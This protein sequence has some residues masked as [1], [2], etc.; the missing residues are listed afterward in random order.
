MVG[1]GGLVWRSVDSTRLLVNGEP[2][3]FLFLPRPSRRYRLGYFCP[4]LFIHTQSHI[5]IYIVPKDV[6]FLI[7]IFCRVLFFPVFREIRA[8]STP[9]YALLGQML[10]LSSPT[11]EQG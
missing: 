11:Y 2:L 3:F 7:C 9:P 1:G 4:Y 8:Y 10:S 5:C 6:S